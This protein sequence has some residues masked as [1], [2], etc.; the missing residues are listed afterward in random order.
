MGFDSMGG[1]VMKP[2]SIVA[3]SAGPVRLAR[4][5][6][7]EGS[8]ATLRTLDTGRTIVR[9]IGMLWTVIDPL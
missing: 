6:S 4:V 1:N 5:L 2:G 7:I 3:I 8:R 9:P